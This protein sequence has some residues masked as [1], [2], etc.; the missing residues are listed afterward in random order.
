MT[1]HHIEIGKD[2]CA[3]IWEPH[4]LTDVV[5]AGGADAL[6]LDPMFCAQGA[7]ATAPFK[8]AGGEAALSWNWGG[9]KAVE[10]AAVRAGRRVSARKFLPPQP[11][12]IEWRGLPACD[13]VELTFSDAEGARG[14][15]KVEA[16][17]VVVFGRDV[18]FAQP[19]RGVVGIRL[20]NRLDGEGVVVE[21]LI[22]GQKGGFRRRQPTAFGPREPFANVPV[23]DFGWGV[24]AVVS[25]RRGQRRL[26]AYAHYY[27]EKSRVYPQK[28]TGA[29]AEMLQRLRRW[30]G[31]GGRG[32]QRGRASN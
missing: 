29:D 14:V 2:G 32:G 15:V 24:L 11:P 9:W 23:F 1:P 26:L 30:L 19:K 27:G 22:P 10:L 21:R 6:A 25:H 8:V 3:F 16:P 17:R 5:R 31:E 28:E 18:E 7:A 4:P 12:E 20:L 13:A